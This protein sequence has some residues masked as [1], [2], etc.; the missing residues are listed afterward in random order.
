MD[1]RNEA[2]ETIVTVVDY[3]QRLEGNFLP[4]RD[5]HDE[6]W[7]RGALFIR[8]QVMDLIRRHAGDDDNDFRLALKQRLKEMA[9][10]R[11]TTR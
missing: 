4:P 3:L 8:E 2:I 11:V 5:H 10:A 7:Q 1:V 9:D 6:D